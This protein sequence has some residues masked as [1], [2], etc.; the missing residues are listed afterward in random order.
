[1]NDFIKNHKGLW[2]H[3]RKNAAKMVATTLT[4]GMLVSTVGFNGAYAMDL[5]SDLDAN[6][7]AKTAIE[8]MAQKNVMPGYTD[9]TYKPAQKVS[10]VELVTVAYRVLKESNQLGSFNA[11]DSVTRN[12][13]ALSAAKIPAILSPYSSDVYT[14]FGFALDN[15]LITKEELSTYVSSDKLVEATKEQVATIMGKTLNFVKKQD[16]SSKIVSLSFNDNDS[17]NSLCAPYI[18][19]LID[20]KL[21]GKDGDA[22]GNFLPRT[23]L[24]RD[25]V[26]N[27]VNGVYNA[28]NNTTT[29]TSTSTSTTTTTTTGSA[30]TTTDTSDSAYENGTISGTI[31][32]ILTDKLSIEVKDELG[33]TAVYSLTGTE[34][35]KNNAA[36]GFLN[37]NVGE[38]VIINIVN[39]KANKVVVEKNYSKAEGTFVELSKSVVDSTTKKNFRV[40]T[41][42]KSDGKLEYYKI[43]TGL[44][45]EIDSVVKSV[46]EIKKNDRIVISYDGYFARKIA[47]YSEKSEVLITLVKV[48]DFKKNSSITYKLQDGRV[49]DQTLKADLELASVG[50]GLKKGDIVKATYSYGYITKLE[51]TGLV[52]EDRGV[53]KEILISDGTSKI[54]I[55]NTQ[56]V[57]KT[58]GIQSKIIMT[59]GDAKVSTDGLYQL[60][61]GQDVSLSMDALGVYSLTVNKTSD[62]MKLS[63]T[64]MEIVKGTNLLKATDSEGKVWIVNLKDGAAVIDNF[65]PGDKIEVTGVK[66]SDLIFEA[67]LMTKQN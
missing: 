31:T 32:N 53:I 66:L 29:S 27:M 42:K 62:K 6:H 43:E 46:E 3:F 54:T 60:R 65:V 47:A 23:S 48:A 11:A 57:R 26:A 39:S 25:I 37:L 50:T 18:S 40:I 22:N 2:T 33:K 17:I 19:L 67:E 24:G 34:I 13:T 16:L 7:W 5:F 15:G 49:L 64:L 45:V 59:I 56:N 51:G 58:Y 12:K 10:K 35:I 1:M 63:L 36:I 4:L 44:Y 55:L 20:Y 52:A 8:N 38:N 30:S 41:L 61:I 9:A 14:A 28:I 21:V